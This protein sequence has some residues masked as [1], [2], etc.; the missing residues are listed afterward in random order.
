MWCQN[1]IST[2]V[3]GLDSIGPACTKGPSGGKREEEDVSSTRNWLTHYV[4][5]EQYSHL[6]K[7]RG[8]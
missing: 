2:L 8:I 1:D 7:A 6:P 5:F 4:F 3:A